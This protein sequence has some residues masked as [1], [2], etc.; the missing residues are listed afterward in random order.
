MAYTRKEYMGGI[1]GSKIVRFTMG[2]TARDFTHTVKIVATKAGQIR[3]NVLEAA[4]DALRK[5][6]NKLPLPM[7]MVVEANS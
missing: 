1:P 3:H 6:S 5:A 2:N 7:K 4:K